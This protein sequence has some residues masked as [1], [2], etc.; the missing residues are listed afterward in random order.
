MAVA[1]PVVLTVEEALRR[2]RENDLEGGGVKQAHKMLARLRE[3]LTIPADQLGG[4]LGFTSAFIDIP[5]AAAQGDFEWKAYVSNR[6]EQLICEVV[7]PGI[8]GIQGRFIAPKDPNRNQNRFDFIAYRQDGSAVRF[9]PSSRQDALPVIGHLHDWQLGQPDGP[10]RSIREEVDGPIAGPGRNAG[11]YHGISFGDIMKHKTV[12]NFLQAREQAWRE[13]TLP[14]GEYFAKS[15][16]GSH[17]FPPHLFLARTDEGRRISDAEVRDFYVVWVAGRWRRSGFYV[18]YG[19][20]PGNTRETVLWP[21]DEPSHE[22]VGAID[23][24]A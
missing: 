15:L 23:W 13:Q 2:R 22:A 16:V 12:T 4:R 3:D 11:V 14:A 7:G 9:H 8:V 1:R 19:A 18:R 5:P 24:G 10:S 21:R 6:A 17:E 20:Q